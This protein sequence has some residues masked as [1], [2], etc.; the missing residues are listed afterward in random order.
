MNTVK[1]SLFLEAKRTFSLRFADRK[2]SLFLIYTF[3]INQ[4]FTALKR[5]SIEF[6]D[7]FGLLATTIKNTLNTRNTCNKHEQYILQT[8]DILEHKF[9]KYFKLFLILI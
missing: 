7:H 2:T 6:F 5:I 1:Q 9:G 8:I 3:T 4:L